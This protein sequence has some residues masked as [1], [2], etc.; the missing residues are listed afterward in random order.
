MVMQYPSTRT[1]PPSSP[2]ACRS[3]LADFPRHRID[4]QSTDSA[5]SDSIA[6]TSSDT[7]IIPR[8]SAP[9]AVPACIPHFLYHGQYVSTQYYGFGIGS[10]DEWARLSR[11][12]GLP[13]EFGP[14]IAARIT[15]RIKQLVGFEPRFA[16]GLFMKDAPEPLRKAA[17]VYAAEEFDWER[18]RLEPDSPEYL[19]VKLKPTLVVQVLVLCRA[20]NEKVDEKRKLPTEGQLDRMKRWLAEADIYD[21]P[22]WWGS[23]RPSKPPTE[24]DSDSESD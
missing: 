3:A 8:T 11:V 4:M 14:E 18:S 9:I 21:E 1:N 6:A 2:A 22:C 7:R 24:V 16:C 23:S 20:K 5:T 10:A 19:K 12:L 17:E 13:E 15:E